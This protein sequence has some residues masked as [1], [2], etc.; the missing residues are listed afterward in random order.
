M[1]FVILSLAVIKV[2]SAEI[3]NS[4][5][6]RTMWFEVDSP[7]L[8]HYTVFYYPN[9]AQNGEKNRQGNEKMAEFPAD[10]SFGVIGGLEQE[11]DYLFSIAV[12]INING[13]IFLGQRTNPAPPG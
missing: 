3:I 13:K 11:Q 7:N 1:C 4:T 6:V 9:P 12:T 10:E 8:D 2:F 5:T